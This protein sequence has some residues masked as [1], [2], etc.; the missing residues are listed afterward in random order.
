MWSEPSEPG[1]IGQRSFDL[2]SV[3]AQQAGKPVPKSV[4]AA[5]VFLN[6]YLPGFDTPE[7]KELCARIELDTLKRLLKGDQ[8]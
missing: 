8:S 2:I 6:N 1:L 3:L 7:A 4:Q 5:V